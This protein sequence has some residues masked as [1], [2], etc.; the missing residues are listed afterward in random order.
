MLVGGGEIEGRGLGAEKQKKEINSQRSGPPSGL[1]LA[2][3]AN[4][5]VGALYSGKGR[6][7]NLITFRD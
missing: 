2:E 1:A 5:P 3:A 7:A 4:I 6:K